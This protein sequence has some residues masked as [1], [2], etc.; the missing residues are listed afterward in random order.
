M[1][2]STVANGRTIR[3]KEGEYSH[4]PITGG[5]RESTTMIRR[6]DRV[7]STGQMEESTKV[8][9]KMVNNME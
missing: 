6:R 2:D 7:C 1:A 3:W 9:G 8:I 4:G 5:T